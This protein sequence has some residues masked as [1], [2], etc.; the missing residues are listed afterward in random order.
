[1]FV[2]FKRRHFPLNMCVFFKANFL[3]KLRNLGEKSKSHENMIF[4]HEINIFFCLLLT[5]YSLPFDMLGISALTCDTRTHVCELW[6]QISSQCFGERRS[7]NVSHFHGQNF[8][9]K[10]THKYRMF[11][12]SCDFWLILSAASFPSVHN[13][14]LFWWLF[15]TLA[16]NAEELTKCP[17]TDVSTLIP[18]MIYLKVCHWFFPKC[19]YVFLSN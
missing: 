1:M 11:I 10:W 18:Q 15:M 7:R 17:K 2:R 12:E 9:K 14:K 19:K 5:W 3:A 16:I 6:K 13:W 8:H 4:I